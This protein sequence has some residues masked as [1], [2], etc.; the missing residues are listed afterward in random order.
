[1]VSS[2]LLSQPDDV[3]IFRV[4][5]F[6]TFFFFEGGGVNFLSRDFFSFVGSLGDFFGF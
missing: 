1:M 3:F 5:S 2:A 6:N 4:I